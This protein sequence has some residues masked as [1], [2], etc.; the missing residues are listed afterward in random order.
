[1]DRIAL[2]NVVS[3]SSSRRQ[4]NTVKRCVNKL[5]AARAVGTRYDK[6]DYIYRGTITITITITAILIWLR[7]PVSTELRERPS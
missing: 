3:A 5:R 6:R 7:D 4:R 1:V 2:G